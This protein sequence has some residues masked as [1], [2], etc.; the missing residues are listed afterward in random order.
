MDILPEECLMVGDTTVDI[1][2][3]KLSG[4]QTAGVLC[5][6]GSEEELRKAG[7][8]LIL[9]TTPELVKYINLI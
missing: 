5:G 9:R 6:F 8:D 1:I 7:A 4:A 3:G 2:A